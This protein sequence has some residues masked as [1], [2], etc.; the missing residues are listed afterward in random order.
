MRAL[1]SSALIALA[2]ASLAGCQPAVAPTATATGPVLSEADAG[3]IADATVA[4]WTSMDAARIKALYAPSVVG[5][6]FAYGPLVTDRAAWDKNQDG[7]AAAKIDRAEMKDRKIQ[8]LDAATFVM[9][10]AWDLFSKALPK[11]N[12]AIRCTDVFH[13][14]AAG[15]WP[16]VN[17][18]CSAVPKTA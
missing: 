13:K 2:A 1:T 16:I 5:F 3:K 18:H 7:F 4:T 17:E 9:S 10:G 8:V 14:D 6:D 15:N 12:A 11:N